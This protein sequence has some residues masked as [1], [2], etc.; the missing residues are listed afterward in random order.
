MTDVCSVYGGSCFGVVVLE[1]TLNKETDAKARLHISLRL[2]P[3]YHAWSAALTF[4]L[5]LWL[6]GIQTG[7][8]MSL[9]IQLNPVSELAGNQGKKECLG[10]KKTSVVYSGR[11]CSCFVRCVP[12]IEVILWSFLYV[13]ASPTLCK[14]YNP[15]VS[16]FP[17]IDGLGNL[18]HCLLRSIL[19]SSIDSPLA[20]TAAGT[21]C[22]YI[23]I[24]HKMQ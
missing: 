8:G 20:P 10:S 18:L 1:P 3:F 19:P 6:A 11:T 24:A 15:R 21:C 12:S 22:L 23:G 4:Y 16:G 13:P 17:L 2:L 7:G 9:Y 5:C 14:I